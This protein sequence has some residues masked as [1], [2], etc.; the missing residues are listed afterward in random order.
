MKKVNKY[1][2]QIVYEVKRGRR[3]KKYVKVLPQPDDS[4]EAIQTASII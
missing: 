1:K 2:W 3:Y 4:R